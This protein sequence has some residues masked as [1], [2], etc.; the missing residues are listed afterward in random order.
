MN[1]TWTTVAAFAAVCAT[2]FGAAEV[3]KP[4]PEFEAKDINGR[5]HKLSDYKGKIVVLESYNLDCPFCANHFKTGAMQELQDWA[6]SKGIVWLLVDS[7]GKQSGSYRDPAAAK[8]EWD[9]L[10]IKATAWIDDHS[11]KVGR[12]YGMKTTPHMFVIDKN[13]VLAYQG[14][15]DDK[16]SVDP[17]DIAGA[18]NWVAAALDALLGGKKPAVAETRSYGC[19]VKYKD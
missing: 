10:K 4:A 12:L 11:G 6:T 19:R 17:A 7:A 15:I 13:G 18:K 8:K 16:A 5:T 1:K 2:A 14:A 3:G 9:D